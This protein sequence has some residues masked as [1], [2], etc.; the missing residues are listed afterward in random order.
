MAFQ[1]QKINPL[2]RQPRKA[3][4]VSLPFSGKAVFNSTYQTKD[5]VKTNLLNF[6]LTGRGE[7]YFN[8]SFGAGLR[9]LFFDNITQARI[10]Q[11][12]DVVTDN[13]QLYFPRVIVRDLNINATPDTNTVT[14]AL[15]YAIS[16]TNATSEEIII[17][18]EQ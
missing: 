9:N 14:L 7:R 16:E 4:G 17:A 3:V 2:D 12:K 10:E 1:V 8:P 11:I 6:F 13:L 15:R 18:F 5:A